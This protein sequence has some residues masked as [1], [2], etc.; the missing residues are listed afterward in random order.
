MT[1]WLGGLG[2]SLGLGVIVVSFNGISNFTKDA[3][4][5]ETE[6]GEELPDC[7]RKDVEAI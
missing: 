7:K 1:S 6:K 5:K 2:H 3:L 4:I